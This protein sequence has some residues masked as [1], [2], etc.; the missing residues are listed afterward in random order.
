MERNK[1]V[2]LRQVAY[3]HE[4]QIKFSFYRRDVQVKIPAEAT[5][6]LWYHSTIGSSRNRPARYLA[7]PRIPDQPRPLPRKT[8]VRKDQGN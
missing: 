3:I 5:P 6:L 8:D 2:F 1:Q 4:Q 7:I